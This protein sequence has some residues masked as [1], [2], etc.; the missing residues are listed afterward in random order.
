MCLLKIEPTGIVQFCLYFLI[1]ANKAIYC[2]SGSTIDL[3][4]PLALVSAALT[5]LLPQIINL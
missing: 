2:R 4:R 1:T 3:S 5:S